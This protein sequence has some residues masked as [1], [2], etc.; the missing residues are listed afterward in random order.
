MS[1]IKCPSC[2]SEKTY[3]AYETKDYFHSQENFSIYYCLNCKVRFTYPVPTNLAQYYESDEYLS[4]DTKSNG[5]I[6]TVYNYL[7]SKNLQIKYKVVENYIHKGCIL[8]IGCGTG[9]LLNYFKS[10]GWETQG[11]EP[12][13]K[14]RN[15]AINNYNLNI[16]DENYLE[17]IN[18][19]FDVITMWHVFEHV[20]DLN[21]RIVNISQL[22]NKNGIII[23]AVPNINSPDS[24]FYKKYWA[25]LD[26]PRHLYHFSEESMRIFLSNHN[27]E[28]IESI[29]MKMDAYYVSM[30]SE[31]YLAHK[32]IWIR[33]AWRGLI[34]NIKARKN[35]NYSSMIF[36]VKMN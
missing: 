24:K 33:A 34:S 7:R 25:A 22:L 11:I 8:D 20:Q 3:L 6:G 18:R 21:K 12:S 9:E 30:L 27:M 5:I 16:N 29:P 32:Y 31:K 10:K 1:T 28:I 19:K 14:A 15:F 4:H 17:T 36:V 23:I 2:E 35:N 26:V 13:Y